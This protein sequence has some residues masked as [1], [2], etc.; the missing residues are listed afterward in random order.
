M[1]QIEEYKQSQIPDK[2]TIGELNYKKGDKKIATRFAY[3]QALLKLGTNDINK[4]IIG[5]DGDTK[6]S[7]YSIELFK[8]FPNNFIECFIAEQNMV[9]VAEGLSCRKKIP[10]VSTFGAFFSRAYDQIRMGGISGLDFVLCGSH[11]GVSIGEDGPSQMAL[12]DLALMK[13]LPNSTV[14]YPSD[15]VSC[16]RAVEICANIKGIKYIRTSRPDTDILYANDEK[17]EVGKC[18]VLV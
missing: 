11:C 14:F 16:E 18:K 1:P 9:G 12:E 6:N 3:G 4:K 17:F 5:L 7:T 8:K 15:A 13:A 10:F 2:F